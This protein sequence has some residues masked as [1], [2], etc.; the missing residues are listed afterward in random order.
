M[1][2][3]IDSDG[4]IVYFHGDG[5]PMS[6]D[7]ARVLR[8]H[9]R[10]S[11]REQMERHCERLNADLDRLAKLHE[12][13]P[14]P[15]HNGYTTQGFSEAPLLPPEP[16]QPAWWHF[17]WPPA[18]QYLFSMKVTREQWAKSTSTSWIKSTRSRPWRLSRYAVI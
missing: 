11:L 5:T 3:D 7:E 12:D 9:A 10:E 2:L 15:H 8:R 14:H 16:C 6:D 4:H 13:T 18:K 17:L 1:R